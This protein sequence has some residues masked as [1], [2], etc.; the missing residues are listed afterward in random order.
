MFFQ[1]HLE[2]TASLCGRIPPITHVGLTSVTLHGPPLSRCFP[3]RNRQTADVQCSLLLCRKHL[4]IHSENSIKSNFSQAESDYKILGLKKCENTPALMRE[5]KSEKWPA[6]CRPRDITYLKLSRL[7]GLHY[8]S[9]FIHNFRVT[10]FRF[11]RQFC[12]LRIKC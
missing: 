11:C 1:F 6:T 5:Q 12:N 8:S 2:V 9:A 7:S 3:I 10:V 4:G